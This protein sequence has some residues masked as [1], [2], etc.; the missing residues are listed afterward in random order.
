M[1][2]N[3][4]W[5]GTWLHQVSLHLESIKPIDYQFNQ[6]Q[7]VSVRTASKTWN[8]KP[9]RQRLNLKEKSESPVGLN[10]W[11][12]LKQVVEIEKSAFCETPTTVISE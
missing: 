1:T 7:D 4:V 9:I 6:F 2:L 3:S 5:D 10:L 12:Q 8:N 11:Q